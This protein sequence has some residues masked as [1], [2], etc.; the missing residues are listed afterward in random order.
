MAGRPNGGSRPTARILNSV[1]VAGDGHGV[2]ELELFFDLILVFAFTQVTQTMAH[3]HDA[4]GILR[5]LIILGLLWWSWIAYAW[6]GNQAYADRGL[7]PIG[8][9]LAAAL[10][11]VIAFAVPEAFADDYGPRLEPFV[12]VIAY[13]LVRL[14]HF[15]LYLIAA[16][17]DPGLKRQLILT[18]SIAVA[19]MAVL[20]AAGAWLGGPAQTWLWLAALVY[21]AAAVFFSSSRGD[22]RVNSTAHAAERFGLVVILALGESVVSMG[23][24]LRGVE[25]GGALIAGVF[26]AVAGNIVVWWLYFHRFSNAV[27]DALQTR[28]AKRLEDATLIYTF[29][30]F[31]IVAGI[32]LTA[33]GIESAM[34][35]IAEWQG[36]GLFGAIAI[37]TGGSLILLATVAIWH[38]V[39]GRILIFRIAVAIAFIPAAMLAAQ[40]PPIAYFSVF[41]LAGAAL[42]FVESRTRQLRVADQA[43]APM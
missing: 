27:K 8:L 36:I 4:P 29:A 12:L 35:H 6:L 10:M 42:V 30:H 25:I 16:R 31:P 11:F 22:F 43:Q 2:N 19:P 5:G 32:L 33:A 34:P 40:L 18:N 7:M 28:S 9:G 38:R 21:D 14:I 20:L 26:L 3:H 1:R 24:G 39:T 15:G 13:V 23:T 17:D 41:V 37:G